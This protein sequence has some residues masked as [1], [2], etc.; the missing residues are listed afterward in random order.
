MELDFPAAHSMDTEWF[1]VDR[2]GHVAVFVSGENGPVPRSV[3]EERM[4]RGDVL[5]DL[6]RSLTG[7]PNT[8]EEEAAYGAGQYVEELVRL[9]MFV[10]HHGQVSDYF[11][12]PY[13]RGESPA[14]PLHIDQLPPGVRAWC[15]CVR[16]EGLRFTD[17]ERVQPLE[18]IGCWVYGGGGYLSSDLTTVR[19]MR[20]F[21]KAYITHCEELLQEILPTGR[22]PESLQNV[23]FERLPA[24]LQKQLTAGQTKGRQGTDGR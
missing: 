13:E 16:F 23:R 12:D 3:D 15:Q 14:Q 20:G 1:A 21:K 9:G 6:L 19:P 17:A 7:K 10:Y 18:S 11:L 22:L 5:W 2:D 4:N 8:A 24:R